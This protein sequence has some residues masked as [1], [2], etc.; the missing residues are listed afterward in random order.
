[1]GGLNMK[2]AMGF[3]ESEVAGSMFVHE[4][5]DWG[6]SVRSVLLFQV[7]YAD[8]D[9]ANELARLCRNYGVTATSSGSYMVQG[10][11]GKQFTLLFYEQPQ[12]APDADKLDF[13]VTVWKTQDGHAGAG[14]AEGRM[15]MLEEAWLGAVLAAS[16]LPD[17]SECDTVT[18]TTIHGK[19]TMD[20][21]DVS[22]TLV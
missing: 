11:S 4:G 3:K 13:P 21:D 5:K 17:F 2:T 9:Y 20:S 15:D 8:G 18:P 19:S 16:V 12:L 14:A 7:A 6:P 22:W 10:Q 1:M